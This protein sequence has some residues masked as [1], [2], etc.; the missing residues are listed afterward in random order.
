[1]DFQIQNEDL[2]RAATF[3]QRR[4]LQLAILKEEYRVRAKRYKRLV[5]KKRKE[6]RAA[7]R[8]YRQVM[9]KLIVD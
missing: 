9:I 5:T 6:V 1:M 8:K 4:Q 3:E 2:E 7:R